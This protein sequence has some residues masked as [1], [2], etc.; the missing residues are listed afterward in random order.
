MD[1]VG[2]PVAGGFAAGHPGSPGLGPGQ[3]Q[4][5]GRREGRSSET[6]AAAA[7]AVAVADRAEELRAED[8]ILLRDG[9]RE[10]GSL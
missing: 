9:G 3:G 8:C 2:L 4:G 7:V 1:T 6:A 10:R 5:P